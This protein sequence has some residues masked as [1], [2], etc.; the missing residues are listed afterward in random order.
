MVLRIGDKVKAERAWSVA[1]ENKAIAAGSP[2]TPKKRSQ[3]WNILRDKL[4]AL[5]RMKSSWGELHDI[6]R[7]RTSA[8]F[9]TL[10]SG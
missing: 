7:M 5:V 1:L 3:K 4:L 8:C 2:K 10:R 9:C 6:V